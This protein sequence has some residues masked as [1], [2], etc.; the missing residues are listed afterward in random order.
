M[1]VAESIEEPA[2]E[3][4]KKKESRDGSDYSVLNKEFFTQQNLEHLIQALFDF[5]KS[6]L[7]G[8]FVQLASRIQ[9]KSTS[10]LGNDLVNNMSPG[11]GAETDSFK[12]RRYVDVLCHLCNILVPVSLKKINDKNV[13]VELLKPLLTVLMQATMNANWEI[14]R[15]TLFAWQTVGDFS[16]TSTGDFNPVEV[17]IEKLT[18]IIIYAAIYT[19]DYESAY[20]EMQREEF[21]DYRNDVRD[22]LRYFCAPQRRPRTFEQTVNIAIKDCLEM[23]HNLETSE[24]QWRKLE[25]SL[26]AVGALNKFCKDDNV[27]L[28]PLMEALCQLFPHL[29]RLHGAHCSAVVL[30]G[31]M[32]LWLNANPKYIEVSMSIV[33]R[34]LRSPVKLDPNYPLQLKQNHVGSIAFEKIG[35]DCGNIISTGNPNLFFSLCKDL[36]SEQREVILD[37]KQDTLMVL[38]GLCFIASYVQNAAIPQSRVER[39]LLEPLIPVFNAVG[40]PD[41]SQTNISSTDLMFACSCLQV[42]FTSYKPSAY[43]TPDGVERGW[44]SL[45]LIEKYGQNVFALLSY[46]NKNFSNLN[47]EEDVKNLEEARESLCKAIKSVWDNVKDNTHMCN[48]Q[49]NLV[50]Y[51]RSMVDGFGALLVKD[52]N[53]SSGQN[54]SGYL[55]VFKSVLIFSVENNVAEDIISNA[56]MEIVRILLKYPR[57]LHELPDACIIFSDLLSVFVNAFPRFII[58]SSEVAKSLIEIIGIG[59]TI[60][61]QKSGRKR[62]K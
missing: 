51:V 2:A 18:E 55:D 22:T 13:A 34:S 30:V 21:H 8:S 43:T 33:L 6:S 58:E 20:D 24:N 38:N 41:T 19:K 36:W 53:T 59:L 28:V 37:N 45:L 5:I 4:K 25:A 50:A 42:I 3:K 61:Y 23:L 27:A 17:V 15:P 16:Y 46:D 35:R 56:V 31:Q 7:S 44:H 49:S 52:L 1:N 11:P 10:T 9:S 40:R 48:D 57:V 47:A 60:R 54:I 39:M 26:H 14:V 62:F 32:S 12:L 29:P